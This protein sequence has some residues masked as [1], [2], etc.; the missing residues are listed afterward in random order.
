[1][2]RTLVVACAIALLEVPNANADLLSD[3]AELGANAGAMKHCRE[4][5]ATEEATAGTNFW[6]WPRAGRSAS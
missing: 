1:M 3:A 5:F 6:P 4:R 2:Y